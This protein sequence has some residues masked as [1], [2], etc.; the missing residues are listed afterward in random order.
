[1]NT[2]SIIEEIKKQLTGDPQKDGPFLKDQSEKYKNEEN[3]A[4]INREL[5]SLLYECAYNAMTESNY[6]YLADRNPLVREKLE[7]VLKR[8]KNLNY[9]GGLK[10]LE[11]I[12]KDNIF[13]WADNDKITYKSFGTPIEHALYMQIYQPEKEVRPVNCN[14][15]EV[16][17]L[18][19]LGLTHKNRYAEA[20]N[21]F[22]KALEFNPTDAEIYVR[23]CEL[24]KTI[25]QNDELRINTD[26]LMHCA[27]T[28]EQLGKGY[29]NYSYYFSEN[30]KF[31]KAS[32]MLEMSRIFL[33]ESKL[34]DNEVEF[35]SSRLGGSYP[36][37]HTREQ[38]MDIM[39]D[40]KI[41]PGPSA[42]VVSTANFL[43][44]HAQQEL[45]YEL[46]KYFYE[47]VFEL[48]ELDEIRE[49]IEN[50]ENDIRSMKKKS[51]NKQI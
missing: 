51:N 9:A 3:S 47:T 11:E 46:A 33:S 45:D 17:S 29:F 5:A 14:M 8:Y 50:L 38:L 16:Y 24:L 15:S 26:K 30:G 37:P 36:P 21:A 41:Q 31:D 39:I 19:G 4:E 42:L 12:I 2:E 23:Y 13:A 25:K 43:A 35:I 27:V 18:Y 34:I 48:T 6:E 20:I 40:E 1:M 7:N 28:K 49:K 10:I 22:Q 32:A 44:K